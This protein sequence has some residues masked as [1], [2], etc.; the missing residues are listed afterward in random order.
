MRI[1]LSMVKPYE[2]LIKSL[3]KPELKKETKGI[4]Y[5]VNS[6]SANVLLPGNVHGKIPINLYANRDHNDWVELT[7]S[8]L[9]FIPFNKFADDV[10]NNNHQYKLALS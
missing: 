10:I 9:S 4:L 2:T 8:I 1:I 6:Q 5:W 7:G 3:S